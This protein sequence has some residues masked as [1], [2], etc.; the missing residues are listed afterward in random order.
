[1]KSYATRL[2]LRLAL[3]RNVLSRKVERR[4]RVVVSLL[5]LGCGS[6]CGRTSE[7]ARQLCVLYVLISDLGHSTLR[8]AH[9][10]DREFSRLIRPAPYGSVKNCMITRHSRSA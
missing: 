4:T 7:S 8:V 10:L 6:L 2:A 1:M 3:L 9:K 5:E